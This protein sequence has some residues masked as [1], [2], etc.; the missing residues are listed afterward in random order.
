MNVKGKLTVKSVKKLR[1]IIGKNNIL[2]DDISR[3]CHSY[4]ATT[5]KYQPDGVAIVREEK[6]IQ[7]IVNLANEEEFYII[8]RGAGTGM[9]GGTLPI[10]GG[11][12]LVLDRLNKCE[13]KDGFIPTIFAQAGVITSDIQ[14]LALSYNYIYPPDPASQE[15]STIGGNI[16]VGAGG[17]RGLKYG[18]TRDYILNIRFV[19]GGGERKTLNRGEDDGIIDL[20]IGSEGTLGVVIS[21]ELL[22]I[23][24]P[25]LSSTIMILFNSI[26]KA[27]RAV[28]RIIREGIIPSR[29]EFMDEFSL[30]AI[31]Q[32]K[33]PG[34]SQGSSIVLLEADGY[35]DEVDTALGRAVEIARKEGAFEVRLARDNIEEQHFWDIRRNI[36]P[37][38]A[39]LGP[40]KVNEDI[41]VPPDKLCETIEKIHRIAKYYDI[42]IACF[43]HVGDGNIHIN[44][45]CDRNNTKQMKRVWDAVSDIFLKVIDLGGTITGEHGVGI[46][47]STYLRIEK[48]KFEMDLYKSIKS[49]FDPK[50]IMNPGKIF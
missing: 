27:M 34:V 48:S 29:L 19:T 43:G 10:A 16:V 45:I 32:Y 3:F 39:L 20:I 25:E 37:A 40:S 36:S 4:D 1:E 33:D 8:P 26:Y 5:L 13:F 50:E 17:P 9:S 2:T 12:V 6:Q 18:T 11:L 21:A 46:T 15:Y 44:I 38:L 23:K 31:K 35:K 28:S 42:F 41:T 24:K 7:K 14:N 49:Q 30:K 47:K 22:L